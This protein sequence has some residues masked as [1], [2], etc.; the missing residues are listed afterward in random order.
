MARQRARTPPPHSLCTDTNFLLD[1]EG[2]GAVCTQAN[3]LTIVKKGIKGLWKKRFYQIHRG[4]VCCVTNSAD[5]SKLRATPI[6]SLYV[7]L[8]GIFFSS[9]MPIN[10]PTLWLTIKCEIRVVLGLILLCV[11]A[12]AQARK[13]VFRLVFW[14]RDI[15][16]SVFFFF[17]R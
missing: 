13:G 1:E 2:R 15:F 6:L 16:C 11:S 12:L 7:T 10:P 5:L 3:A 4:C 14:L 17:S 8:A 9:P